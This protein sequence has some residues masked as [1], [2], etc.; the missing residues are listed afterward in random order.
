M[1]HAQQA[2]DAKERTQQIEEGARLAREDGS[3]RRPIIKA[4]RPY[5]ARTT[6]A[7]PKKEVLK[8]H[9]LFLKA[10]ET[11]GAMVT[12]QK[13]DGTIVVGTIKHSDKFTVSVRVASFSEGAGETFRDRVIFKHDISEFSA[14]TPRPVESAAPAEQV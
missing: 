3:I 14:I 9:E 8:G 12:I 11:S 13:R 2:F 1:L 7:A 4:T 10:L 6:A 5:T